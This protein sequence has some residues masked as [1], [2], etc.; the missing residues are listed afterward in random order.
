MTAPSSSEPRRL[1]EFVR[2]HAI[3]ITACVLA[4]LLYLR[5]LHAPFLSW[6]DDKNISLN[7]YYL[8]LG[9]WRLWV[10]PYF[11]VYVPVISSIWAALFK[12]GSGSAEP[13]RLFNAVVHV[14]NC[15]LVAR[16]LG[17]WFS[18]RSIT[19]PTS[20][21]AIGVGVA[22]FALHPLQSAAVAWISGGRDLSATAF[23][24]GAILVARREGRRNFLI[25]TGLFALGLLCKPSIAGVPLLLVAHDAL[26]EK[27]RLAETIRRMWVWAALVVATAVGTNL[28]QSEMTQVSVAI[29]RR[30]LVALDAA[31]FYLLKVIWPTHLS[32]DYGRTPAKLFEHPG[33]LAATVTAFALAGA[34]LWRV[35]KQPSIH[36][37][38]WMWLLAALPVLGVITFAFQRIS[39]V[40]DHYMYLP[41]AAVG[42]LAAVV[43]SR[44]NSRSIAAGTAAAAVLLMTSLTWQRV[45]AWQ[46]SEAYFTDVLAKNPDSWSALTNLSQIACERGEFDWGLT[47]TERSLTI[48]P[49]E[50]AA[51]ANRAY[52]LFHSR[53]YGD[54]VGMIPRLGTE[55]VAFNLEHNDVAAGSLANTI[56]GAF[57]ELGN[58][59]QGAK[60]LCQAQATLPYDADLKQNLAGVSAQLE[61]KGVDLRCGSRRPWRE[62]FTGP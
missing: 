10:E 5:L 17:A 40:A 33:M 25:A 35:R 32:G 6:D 31:G 50:A 37:W 3:V 18:R 57:F 55:T 59:D 12:I 34:G 49:S 56:A 28:M 26:V 39:T 8:H 52:C 11:G 9:W 16:L 46:S 4:A 53:R 27:E 42:G 44:V 14:L 62:V 61:K 2:D 24:L 21:L 38:A 30:P 13:F 29:V 7:P 51:L 36:V 43:V 45:A 23:A 58:A 22:I 1:A 41:M 54:V 20:R 48:A 15:V 60:Y 47:L 19:G